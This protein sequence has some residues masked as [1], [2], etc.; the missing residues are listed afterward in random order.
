MNLALL[1]LILLAFA[2]GAA[3]TAY[4]VRRYGYQQGYRRAYAEQEIL[5]DDLREEIDHLHEMVASL[6]KQQ[7]RA[8]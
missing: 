2:S 8:A 6:S 4:Y 1:A 3:A 5:V 7:R